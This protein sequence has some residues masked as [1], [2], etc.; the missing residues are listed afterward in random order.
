M[1]WFK[2]VLIEVKIYGLD[3]CRHDYFLLCNI[4][5]SLKVAMSVLNN[6]R[7]LV[8]TSSATAIKAL[9][10]SLF[11][12]RFI[13]PYICWRQFLGCV[14]CIHCIV[15][16]RLNR[17]KC[18]S[19]WSLRDPRHIVVVLWQGGRVGVF[20][21]VVK[22]G[23]IQTFTR[24][25]HQHAIWSLLHSDSVQSLPNYFGLFCYLWLTKVRSCGISVFNIP[26]V[27]CD[28]W[29]CMLIWHQL[30]IIFIYVIDSCCCLTLSPIWT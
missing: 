6:S 20:L 18:C 11:V 29:F 9:L 23:N 27:I 2:I 17:S 13:D 15:Q 16:E 14:R 12:C 26:S 8:G 1:C 10:G 25:C 19:G 28:I 7:F 24:W 21:S 30:L 3:G 22:F 4:T 5:V